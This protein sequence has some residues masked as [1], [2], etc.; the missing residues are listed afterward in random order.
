MWDLGIWFRGDNGS[1]GFVVGQMILKV[2][3]NLSDSVN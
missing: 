1:A 2:S 3:S